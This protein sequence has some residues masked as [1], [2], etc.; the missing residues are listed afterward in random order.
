MSF[1]PNT[2]RTHT[3][4]ELRATHIGQSVRL[5]GWIHAMRE[6][7]GV[8]FV[9]L[10][11]RFGRTQLVIDDRSTNTL[12]ELARS[13]RHES[14]IT[15][16]GFVTERP[17]GKENNFATGEVEVVCVQLLVY[18]ASDPLP[19]E[20]NKEQKVAEELRL[21]YRFLDLRR[22]RL[23]RNMIQRAT[24][25]QMIRRYL[26]QEHGFIE[27]HTPILANSSPE[28]ARDFLVP[29][30]LH[31]GQFYALP[32][33]PQQFKQLLMVAGFE[34]YFQ[35]A[36]CFRD[37]DA[38]AD[39][40]PGEFYQ[41]DLEMSF[42]EQ[43]D[44]F[45]VVEGLMKHL[46]IDF[47]HRELVFDPFIRL[48][49]CDAMDRFGSDKPDLTFGLE[50]VDFTRCLRESAFKLLREAIDRGGV[51]KGLVVPK[52]G[53]W[54]KSKFKK[55]ETLAKR[56]GSAGLLGFGFS[57]ETE[58]GL[59]QSQNLSEGER[60][61]IRDISGADAADLVFVQFGK[62]EMV[63]KV[64]GLLR[65]DIADE[66]ALRDHQRLAW[67]WITNFPMYEYSET[68][69]KIVFAHNPFSMPI[70]GLEALNSKDPLEITAYQYDLF[71]NG[72]E[73]SS[74][75]VRNFDPA[76]MYRAFE[77]VGHT[78][79]AVDR[80]FGHM[81]RAFRL[82]APPHAGI[83]PGIER[84]LMVF[85]DEPNIREVVPFP[86]NQN[87]QDLMSGAPSAVLAKQLQELHIQIIPPKTN[88]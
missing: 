20:V 68:E 73:L 63:N 19:F 31:P 11:D 65:L 35:V 56:H 40:S 88:E 18:T 30:R 2:Y 7:K 33:A 44:V 43:E 37:E 9:E 61:A 81:I 46:T 38:R 87:A 4:G 5:S 53:A 48:T 39:R 66:L 71:C 25:I 23:S 58:L 29:S 84:A 70:G 28:G 1:R 85:L 34:R 41:L 24:M 42:V 82:G 51:V 72:V 64:L 27:I 54:S 57:A 14:T 32:Q 55:F 52:G 75:A 45:A 62:R 74:G 17:E 77:I 79:E 60:H 10:R 83:A 36:P 78:R 22:E 26:E 15:V 13:L 76:I 69:K 67:G 86:K 3:C 49:Y 8:L 47:A 80:E 59:F 12:R 50:L 16:S 6:H 21:R